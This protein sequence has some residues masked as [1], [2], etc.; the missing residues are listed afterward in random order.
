MVVHRRAVVAGLLGSVTTAIAA[1]AP[2][3]TT[4]DAPS[5]AMPTGP[6]VAVPPPALPAAPAMS[7]MPRSSPATTALPPWRRFAI[8][9]A[10]AD[11]RPVISVVIDDLGVV[12]GGTERAVALPGP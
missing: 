11:G 5:A 1:A 2:S 8:A 7:P 6:L 3:L 9:P 12:R 4:P 10:Q